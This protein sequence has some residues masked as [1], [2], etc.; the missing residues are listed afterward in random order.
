[1]AIS[2]KGG[3]NLEGWI[4]LHRKIQ[5][6]PFFQEKRT[7]SKFEA[8]VDLMLLANHKDNKFMLGNEM[9][10]VEKGGLI[11]SEIKLMNRWGWSKTKVRA[12]LKLLEDDEMIV[13]KS[14]SK[15][16]AINL[17]K[18]SD[19]QNLQTAEKPEKNRKETAE[20][21]QK[22]TN[23]NVNNVIRKDYAET[24]FLT[25][26]EY[27][28]LIATYGEHETKYW[29]ERLDEWQ[30]N[31]PKKQKVNHYKTI[32]VWIRTEQKR[33][34]KNERNVINLPK[35]TLTDKERKEYEEHDRRQALSRGRTI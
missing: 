35:V 24:V 31:N 16:T 8:W 6:H 21:P 27:Q 34:L 19:Y 5:D 23:N 28:K 3:E 13:K 26:V 9:V 10:E 7:F 30:T 17:C 25:E 32:Q 20:R 1:L 4:S 11:T 2:T 14:D 29:I 22:D 12:F 15:K 33:K 18:Y